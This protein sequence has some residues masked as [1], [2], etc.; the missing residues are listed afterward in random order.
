[1]GRSYNDKL[2]NARA[3]KVQSILIKANISSSRL[4]V[5]AAGEDSSVDKDSEL[6]RKLVRKVTFRVK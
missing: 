4:N 3:A 6:A 5:I 2:S 1:M